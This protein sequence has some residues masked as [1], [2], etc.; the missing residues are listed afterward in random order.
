MKIVRA[1][2]I[3]AED[4]GPEREYLWPYVNREIGIHLHYGG[5]QASIQLG[6]IDDG[7]KALVFI[8]SSVKDTIFWISFQQGR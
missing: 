4:S 1:W 7:E 6:R 5:D 3:P 8:D 2:W